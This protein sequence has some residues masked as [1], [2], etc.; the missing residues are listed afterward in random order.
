MKIEQIELF[1]VRM[2]LIYPWRTS[3]GSDAAIESVLVKMTSGNEFGW[4]ESSALAAPCYSPEYAGGL[5]AVIRDWLAPRLLKQD[6]QSGDQLQE[7]LKLFKG[8]YFAKAA[9]DTAWWDLHAKQVGKPLYQVLGGKRNEIDAGEDFG[10]RDSIEELIDLVGQ[11]V[12]S[13]ASRVKLKFGP[14]WDFPVVERV[15]KEF[16]KATLHIDCNS[17]YRLADAELF[18]RLDQFNLSMYEQPLAFDDLHEHAQLQKK[19]RTPIC[20]DETLNSIERAKTAIELGSCKWANIKPGRVGGITNAVKMHDLF[21]KHHIP[22]WVGGMLESAVGCMHCAALATLPNF[23]YAAD[24]F[25]TSKFYLEDLSEPAMEFNSP[26]KFKLSDVAGI[27]AKPHA[28]RLKKC[29]VQQVT[30]K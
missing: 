6:I 28:E 17:N 8:N 3:Y 26:W 21:E 7:R 20:L 2:P 11:A 18:E 25:P 29:T 15:R 10:I 30:L 1:H 27:G 19:V 23:K 14:G 4:G 24:V 12:S 5:F 22:C 13:G 9:L 16:P